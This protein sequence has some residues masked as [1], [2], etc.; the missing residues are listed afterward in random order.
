M[1]V[2]FI[3]HQKHQKSRMQ[4]SVPFQVHGSDV[5]PGRVH[6]LM[7]GRPGHPLPLQDAAR[8]QDVQEGGARDPDIH[9]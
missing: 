5:Q 3:I 4:A 7:P 6:R 1:E 2:S 9:Q 8:G